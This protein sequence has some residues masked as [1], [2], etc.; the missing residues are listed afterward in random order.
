MGERGTRPNPL[1]S[2]ADQ[3]H[4][5]ENIYADHDLALNPWSHACIQ[6]DN[7]RAEDLHHLAEWNADDRKVALGR[8][9]KQ[10]SALYDLLKKLL[11]PDPAV[12][13]SHFEAGIQSV[14]GHHFF[15]GTD[16]EPGDKRSNAG[17]LVS[18]TQSLGPIKG[19]LNAQASM[20]CT[21]LSTPG[22]SSDTIL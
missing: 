10:N 8:V 9:Y 18:I 7:I 5:F 19:R 4:V 20:L 16:L 15:S 6:D 14:L 3:L 11:E 22:T 2:L 1:H 21:L 13:K 12:R 17:E